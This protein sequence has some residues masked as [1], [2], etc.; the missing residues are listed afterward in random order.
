MSEHVQIFG[1]ASTLV[2]HDHGFYRPKQINHSLFQCSNT[3]MC[4]QGYP[5]L[6]T[7]ILMCIYNHNESDEGV[8]AGLLR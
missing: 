7:G 1:I 8:L 5:Y 6:P 3:K 4:E 2:S